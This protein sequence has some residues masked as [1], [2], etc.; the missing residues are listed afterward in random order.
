LVSIARVAVPDRAQHVELRLLRIGRD[1]AR[2]IRDRLLG[3]V[4]AVVIVVLLARQEA[5]DPR[6][7]HQVGRDA[8]DQARDWHRDGEI[9]VVVG[10][11]A[12]QHQRVRRIDGQPFD[13]D[14][15][16]GDRR[17]ALLARHRILD[18]DRSAGIAGDGD[19]I[20]LP[21]RGVDLADQAAGRV[22]PQ[23][24]RALVAGQADRARGEAGAALHDFARADRREL[25]VAIGV[26]LG[27]EALVELQQRPILPAV[28]LHR[29]RAHQEVALVVEAHIAAPQDRM[30]RRRLRE[31]VEVGEI[32]ADL[33]VADIERAGGGLVDPLAAGRDVIGGEDMARRNQEAGA[34]GELAARRLIEH[35]ADRAAFGA[36][37]ARDRMTIIRAERHG[38]GGS[39]VQLGRQD[40]KRSQRHQGSQERP[41]FTPHPPASPQFEGHRH[42]IF[43]AQKSA[44]SADT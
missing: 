35:E 38:G 17:N 23:A 14:V 9:V 13:R 1:R 6:I 34:G 7:V 22:L 3:I 29:L 27:A 15:R 20:M 30:R 24:P 25:Q 2:Q 19:A 5:E 10:I 36:L 8:L 16:D 40:R 26:R 33:A 42:R 11:V 43:R 31:A 41:N 37:G 32:G 28:A 4:G 21:A 12:L 18:Q 44:Q 39:D